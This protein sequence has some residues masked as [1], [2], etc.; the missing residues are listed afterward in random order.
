MLE[1]SKLLRR[2]SVLSREQFSYLLAGS[3]G[4]RGGDASECD[5]VALRLAQAARAGL[6][7]ASIPARRTSSGSSSRTPERT[8]MVTKPPLM[9]TF[10]F[11]APSY[12]CVCS[13]SGRGRGRSK[14]AE[15]ER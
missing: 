15:G 8:V 2:A 4:A 13:S 12:T 1:A 7:S 3:G 9:T 10:V 5:A 11:V 6:R 14:G